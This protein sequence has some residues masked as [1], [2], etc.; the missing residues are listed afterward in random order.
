MDNH[1]DARSTEF[2]T[3][4]CWPAD[5]VPLGVDLPDVPLRY[6]RFPRF[7]FERREVSR[8]RSTRSFYGRS[9]TGSQFAQL[10]ATTAHDS[11]GR[12]PVPSAGDL[13][14][15][16]TFAIA[17]RVQGLPHGQLVHV[18]AEEAA[19]ECLWEIDA[20]VWFPIQGFPAEAAALVI[21]VGDSNRYVSRYGTRGLRFMML[22]AGAIA[23]TIDLAAT[24]L[25]LATC[26]VGGFPDH[27]V[28]EALNLTPDSGLWPTVAIA[29]GHRS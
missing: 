7:D 26:W 22:E 24:G 13:G 3:S 29:I 6:P 27:L 25:G 11:H 19:F 21:I 4:S 16:H 12:R 17:N 5:G 10:L 14:G 1:V 18:L 23:T 15:V 9:I 8:R 20:A 2:W 28:V